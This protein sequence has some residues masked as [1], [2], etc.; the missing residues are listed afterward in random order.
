MVTEEEEPRQVCTIYFTFISLLYDLT[1]HSITWCSS[2]SLNGHSLSCKQ[3]RH[4]LHL[5]KVQH[6]A[7]TRWSG[8]V[9]DGREKRMARWKREKNLKLTRFYFKRGSY[10]TSLSCCRR[11]EGLLTECRSARGNRLALKSLV[12]RKHE[13]QR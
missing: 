1:T 10:I 4:Y 8:K 7:E 2:F 3:A 13:Q 12:V 11:V 9:Q 6:E 5:A